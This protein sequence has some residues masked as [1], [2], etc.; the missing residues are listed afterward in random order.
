M[1]NNNRAPSPRKKIA[2]AKNQRSI[3][4]LA[5][6]AL[7]PH[8][9]RGPLFHGYSRVRTKCPTCGYKLDQENSGD[10]PSAFLLLLIGFPA[11]FIVS[12]LYIKYNP[13]LWLLFAV[14]VAVVALGMFLLLRPLKALF[15]VIQYRTKS[16]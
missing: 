4:A 2:P 1:T 16:E 14:L 3:F 10:G 12:I 13:P 6:Y 5:L 11:I 9:G 15:I 8:C 7:C